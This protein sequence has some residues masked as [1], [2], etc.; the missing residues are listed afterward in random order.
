MKVLSYSSTSRTAETNLWVLDGNRHICITYEYEHGSGN[1][2]FA[3]TVFRPDEFA[4]DPCPRLCQDIEAT[5]ARRF[6]IRQHR[7]ERHPK[8][9]ELPRLGKSSVPYHSLN[10]NREPH[11][12]RP[13]ETP[14]GNP[15]S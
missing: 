2:V 8:E 5:T 15:N 13:H 12:R 3:A 14:S 10:R 7:F 1:I 6:E 4:S 9:S 11:S